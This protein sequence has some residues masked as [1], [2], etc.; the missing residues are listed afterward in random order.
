MDTRINP[1]GIMAYK[2]IYDFSKQLIRDHS[3]EELW[4]FINAVIKYAN[5]TYDQLFWPSFSQA[6]KE[7]L[8]KIC[9][10]DASTGDIRLNSDKF[11]DGGF[12]FARSLIK[13]M[14]QQLLESCKVVYTELNT[15]TDKTL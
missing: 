10:L 3:R 2:I 4:G 8:S 14:P 9:D 5:V 7:D 13:A 6:S 1:S 12:N 11:N 15:N